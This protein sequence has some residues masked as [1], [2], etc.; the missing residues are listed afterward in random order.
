M[1]NN[2]DFIPRPKMDA[3][4]YGTLVHRVIAADDYDPA[5]LGLTDADVAELGDLVSANQT[6]L[7]EVDAIKAMLM[8]KTKELSGPNGNHQRMVAKLRNIGNKARVS[9]ATAPELA[10]IS[11]RRRKTKPTRRNAPS[12]AP[13]LTLEL[14][15]PGVI[16]LRVRET[17]SASPRARAAN[18]NGIQIAVVDATVDYTDNEANEVPIKTVSHSPMQLDT[19]GW[20]AKVRLYA[21]WQSLRGETSPWSLPLPITVM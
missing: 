10:M 15:Q 13:G 12:D 18:A 4:S 7:A 11:V 16:R 3:T 6:L 9:N 17:G 2:S 5:T 19:T 21:R 20:P 14:A 1:T 8:A